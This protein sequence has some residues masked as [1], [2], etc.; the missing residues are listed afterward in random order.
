M[1]QVT[2][3]GVYID[4]VPSGVHTITGV[5]TSIAAFFGRA[6]KGRINRA[7]RVTSL[8]DFTRLFGEPHAL[9][10]LAPS[11]RQFFDN[12]G[13]DCYVVRLAAG[14]VRAN[15]TLRNI[16]QAGQLRVLTV[17]A[18]AEGLYGNNLRLV[19]DYNTPNPDESFNL[20]VLQ[21]EPSPALP[22]EHHSGLVM[23][24]QSPRFAPTFVTQSSLLVDVALH[25]DMGDPTL[26]ASPINAQSP[27][28]FSQ[29]RLVLGTN[30]AG[31]P[32]TITLLNNLCA[33]F[34]H[35]EMSVNDQA[36]ED[37][38]LTGLDFTGLTTAQIRTAIQGALN[39]Q[40]TG[41]HP[42]HTVAVTFDAVD[43]NNSVFRITSTGL[44]TTCVRIRRARANDMALDLMFGVDQGGV[45]VVRFG[46]QRPVFTGS[47]Y[48]G[49][50]GVADIVDGVVGLNALAMTVQTA[51]GIATIAVDGITVPV[52]GVHTVA[53]AGSL[54]FQDANGGSDGIREKLRIVATTL[55]GDANFS[56]N[57]VA[58]LWGYHLVIRRRL[59]SL[60]DV[61]V[62]AS[63]P[64]NIFR[65]AVVPPGTVSNVW[66]YT[67]GA[68]GT[69][70]F[71]GVVV[72]GPGTP[73]DDGAVP[74][75]A[76]YT[77][78][79]LNRTGFFALDGVD[80]FN[81]MVIPGDRELTEATYTLLLAPASIYCASRR[82]FLLI[83][84]PDSWTVNGLPTATATEV[85]GLRS[86]VG[87]PEN[88]AVFYPKVVFSDLGNRRLIGPSGMI[89]GI[90]SRTDSSRGV[91]KAPAGLD[92]TMRGAI[93]LEAVLSDRQNGIL[94]PLAVNCI[95]RFPTGIV[96]WGARTFAGFDNG[97]EDWKYVPVRRTA[98]F[99]EESLYRGTQWVVFEP[100]DE[101]LYASIRK[102]LTAF[103]MGLFRQGAF[104]G[105]S[106]AQAFFVKCDGETTTQNDRNLGIV[107]I[108]VG[109]APLKPAEFVVIHIQQIAG[110]LT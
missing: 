34:G 32:A 31:L 104:Q 96:N 42:G 52:P 43:A 36:F 62:V 12:G 50:R 102:N 97:S 74:G 107:N 61:S 48:M 57:H 78:V 1:V 17:T 45:E 88:S 30:A 73:G 44:R 87:V 18:K 38:D 46:N 94:N 105:S 106:P 89:A 95:R 66:R 20:H 110:E 72:N 55:N 15:L 8:S 54:W 68:G 70:D 103:M 58:A 101:P 5:A 109:F 69:S 26:V 90:M 40:Y 37:M 71:Q 27:P 25:A 65:S 81:L 51:L 29:S 24:P 9:S 14:A 60:N 28:G 83:D 99:L 56:D 23:D 92:A 19:I 91:W 47:A 33:G 53:A 7:E 100:N 13:T 6:S 35:F 77:G 75:F 67:L 59:A 85:N 16:A 39:T 93:D 80:L 10:D 98:L 86:A 4:E 82:A 63:A 21:D 64:V 41:R 84:A 22:D 76:E 2:F 11:V 3:P 79:Q 108:L 49:G